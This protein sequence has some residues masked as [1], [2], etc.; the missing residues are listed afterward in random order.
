MVQ[1][2]ILFGKKSD[3]EVKRIRQIKIGSIVKLKGGKQ[4]MTITKIDTCAKTVNCTWEGKSKIEFGTFAIAS[5]KVEYDIYNCNE[6]AY[7]YQKNDAFY[8][9]LQTE[10][11]MPSLRDLKNG[12][13]FDDRIKAVTWARDINNL[14]ESEI[15]EITYG[16]TP[17]EFAQL[18]HKE[19]IAM[20][21]SGEL[22]KIMKEH[23][24]GS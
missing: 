22:Y 9:L 8:G 18:P 12:V 2:K 24:S 14:I 23:P 7:V 15:T 13:L 6:R 16:I 17:R 21:E 11:K 5:L 4:E 19:R 10:K 1:I 20:A 3:M